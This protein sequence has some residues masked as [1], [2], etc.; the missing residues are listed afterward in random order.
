MQGLDCNYKSV[1]RLLLEFVNLIGVHNPHRSVKHTARMLREVFIIRLR[2][3]HLSV[4][5]R[6]TQNCGKEESTCAFSPTVV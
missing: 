2:F 4:C 1:L 5:F 3:S 6:C